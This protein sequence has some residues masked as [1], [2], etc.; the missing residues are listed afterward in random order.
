[1][2][3]LALKYKRC[4]TLASDRHRNHNSATNSVGDQVEPSYEVEEKANF[5]LSQY[6][7]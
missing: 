7:K 5:E 4:I 3:T 2:Q 6:K 1:M